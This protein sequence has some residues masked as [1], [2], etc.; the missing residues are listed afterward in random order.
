MVTVKV[1]DAIMNAVKSTG[2]VVVL[3]LG[4]IGSAIAIMGKEGGCHCIVPR[5]LIMLIRHDNKTCDQEI[6][7]W[8]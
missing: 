3:G 5:C 1:S 6:I 4:I 8:C 2:K 7:T